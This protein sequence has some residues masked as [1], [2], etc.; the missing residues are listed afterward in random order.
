MN[1]NPLISICIPAY[2]AA[3]YIEEAIDGWRNQTYPYLEILVQ[4]DCSKDDTYN[5]A[6]NFSH[7]DS[8]VKVYRN[9]KNLGIGGNWNEVFHKATGD[10]LVMANADDVYDPNMIENALKIFD[11]EENADAVS[12]NYKI[13][14]D[15]SKQIKEVGIQK[16]LSIGFQE[17]LFR[18]C[19]FHNPFHIIFTVFKTKSLQSITLSNGDLFLNTQICDA[20]LFFRLGVNHLNLYYSDDIG[21]YYRKHETNNSSIKN[22]E[23]YSWLFDVFPRYRQI[24]L[25][26]H[27]K[28]TKE[29]LFNR[30]VH[31]LKYQ[32]KHFHLPD[33]K[34][35]NCFMKE[36]YIFS[37][38]KKIED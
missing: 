22:G 24:L 20:E 6:F 4:D 35:L 34:Q 37:R 12:F 30:I 16:E 1:I 17:E 14:E 28:E 19:F 13:L 38:Y 2:N 36:Y 23:R 31:H 7:K 10:Y 15:Q 29:L 32:L 8:R 11:K 27:Q 25:T 9:K 33:F 21:G 26:N 3:Q 18:Q 5:K